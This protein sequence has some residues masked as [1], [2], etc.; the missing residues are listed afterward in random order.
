MQPLLTTL[1]QNVL[2]EAVCDSVA[3]AK[4]GTVKTNVLPFNHATTGTLSSNELAAAESA[5]NDNDAM[6]ARFIE[7]YNDTKFKFMWPSNRL[8]ENKRRPDNPEYDE[9]T[10]YVPDHFLSTLPPAQ[11][12]WWKFKSRAWGSVMLFKVGKFY[13]VGAYIYIYIYTTSSI[14]FFLI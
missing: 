6:D 11:A 3:E 4:K 1:P 12:Q 5:Y 8:D 10:I 13:E 7:R 2:S 9:K 14:S